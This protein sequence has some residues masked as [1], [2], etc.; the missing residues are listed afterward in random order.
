VLRVALSDSRETPQAG[1]SCLAINRELQEVRDKNEHTS[2]SVLIGPVT[3]TPRAES[4]LSGHAD[5]V[6]NTR[7][8]FAKCEHSTS[9]SHGAGHLRSCLA[10]RLA[11]E[12]TGQ[13]GI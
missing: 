3:T 1:H 12:M 6:S 8:H 2:E 9:D 5:S 7:P 13:T 10:A 11:S 4:L